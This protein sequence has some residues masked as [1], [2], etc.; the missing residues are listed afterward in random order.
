MVSG[1]S[2]FFGRRST[3][4]AASL[5][6][7][8]SSPFA[9]PGWIDRPRMRIRTCA[10]ENVSSWISPTVEPSIVYAATAPKVS[11]GK[12]MTP[13]PTSSSG[14]NATLSGPCGTSGW[15]SEIRGGGHDLGDAGLVVG[16]EERRAVGGDDLVAD[17]RR[18][19]R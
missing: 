7:F 11:T 3:I 6:A 15:A 14:L 2:V 16:A 13:R 8:T 9:S 1:E 5:I 4:A 19:L 18:E 10:P 17:V 12:W